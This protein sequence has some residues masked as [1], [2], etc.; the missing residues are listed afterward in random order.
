MVKGASCLTRE[1]HLAMPGLEVLGGLPEARCKCQLVPVRALHAPRLWS[2][3][4]M[5]LKINGRH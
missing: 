3:I 1:M 5:V 4:A 2:V